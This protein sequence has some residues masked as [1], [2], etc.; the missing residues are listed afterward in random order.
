M[1]ASQTKRSAWPYAIAG[2]FALAITGIAIF[3]TWAVEQNM[4]LVRSDY[5][6]QEILFQ[7]HID[8]VVRTKAL[9]ASTTLKLDT[10]SH[11]LRIQIP[12]THLAQEFSGKLHLYRPSDAKLDRHIELSPAASGEQLLN[13]ADLAPGVWKARAEWTTAGTRY[14]MEQNIFVE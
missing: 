10:K 4:D 11:A 9:G 13:T 8:A 7:Q 3:I 1:T 5:Y 14:L 12:A 6:E 2:Y